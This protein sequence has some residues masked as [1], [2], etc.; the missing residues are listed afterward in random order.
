MEMYETASPTS[1]ASCHGRGLLRS[2]AAVPPS[3]PLLPLVRAAPA[4]NP[5]PDPAPAGTD[6]DASVPPSSAGTVANMRCFLAVWEPREALF[7]RI[8]LMGVEGRMGRTCMQASSRVG[9]EEG[10]GASEQWCAPIL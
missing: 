3:S 8:G 10:R 5:G 9:R 2:R 7:S 6:D 1:A 4:S